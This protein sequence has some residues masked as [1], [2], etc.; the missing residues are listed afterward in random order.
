MVKEFKVRTYL[1]LTFQVNACDRELWVRASSD[2]V[3]PRNTRVEISKV[4]A[5][6]DFDADAD[7]YLFL[8]QP[9]TEDVV[10]TT[11]G[12]LLLAPKYGG[13]VYN[14]G[15][16]VKFDPVGAS[17]CGKLRWG[18]D[19]D[20]PINRDRNLVDADVAEAPVKAEPKKPTLT[21]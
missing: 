11:D 16:S 5:N 4:P 10:T 19:L 21:R 8:R 3:A 18:Y 15:V 20:L 1:S 13:R 2:P 6:Y 17:G 12:K 14:K 9:P 7:N